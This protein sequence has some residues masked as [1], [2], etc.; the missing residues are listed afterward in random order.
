MFEGESKLNHSLRIQPALRVDNCG[1]AFDRETSQ[2]MMLRQILENI[3]RF[4]PLYQELVAKKYSFH[5]MLSPPAPGDIVAWFLL[6]SMA[7]GSV[8]QLPVTV[9]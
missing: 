4:S 5:P 7:E 8:I 1:K 9:T 2:P 6:K 3:P